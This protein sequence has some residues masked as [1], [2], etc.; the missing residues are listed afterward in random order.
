[1][2]TVDRTVVPPVDPGRLFL[3]HVEPALPAAYRLATLILEDRATAEDVVG[4][5]IER[6]WR[7]WAS[8]RDRDHFDGWFTRIVVNACRDHIRRRRR[9]V[10]VAIP[11]NLA[12]REHISDGLATRDAIGRAYEQ[13]DVNERA[14]VVLRLE[15]GLTLDEVAARLAIPVG[16]VKSRFHR[17]VNRMRIELQREER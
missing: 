13:L 8:L 6:A 15:A 10:I 14:V 7:R 17:A 12:A 11:D 5:A 1:M 16:T 2:A 9:L 3:D 4:D